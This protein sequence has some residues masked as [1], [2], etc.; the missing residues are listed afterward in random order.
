M[1]DPATSVTA[2]QLYIYRRFQ[3]SGET[4]LQEYGQQGILITSMVC[5]SDGLV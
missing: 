2:M 4:V 3:Y 1:P 5:K